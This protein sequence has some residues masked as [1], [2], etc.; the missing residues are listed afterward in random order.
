MPPRAVTPITLMSGV[1]AGMT[2]V[3]GMPSFF[4]ASATPC[5]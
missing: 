2:M 3:A 4:A 5:A 1:V